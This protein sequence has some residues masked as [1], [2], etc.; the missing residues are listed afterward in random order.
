[1]SGTWK[2]DGIGALVH[3]IK[4]S[5]DPQ[6]HTQADYALAGPSKGSAK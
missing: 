2:H 3:I 6:A 5:R 1:M 4:Q